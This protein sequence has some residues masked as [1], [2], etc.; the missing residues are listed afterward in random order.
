MS[1]AR[2]IHMVVS[3]DVS[4]FVCD[5]VLP[6]LG[7]GQFACGSSLCP[8]HRI[9]VHVTSSE[10]RARKCAVVA[11]VRCQRLRTGQPNH[12]I[13]RRR[14]TKHVS[15]RSPAMGIRK[16]PLDLRP[17]LSW[18]VVHVRIHDRRVSD[19]HCTLSIQEMQRVRCCLP[20]T[21]QNLCEMGCLYRDTA[22][23]HLACPMAVAQKS[24]CVAPCEYPCVCDPP[25]NERKRIPALPT[26]EVE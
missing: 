19:F 22:L 4:H 3:E 20:K 1:L 15:F 14:P 11:C 17:K 16:I 25:K 2:A 21:L 6:I 26:K 10:F 24:L 7:K 5:H 23:R 12:N 18:T 8:S 9:E 13:G